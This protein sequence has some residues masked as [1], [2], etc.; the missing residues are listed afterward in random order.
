MI[1]ARLGMAGQTEAEIEG[2]REAIRTSGALAETLEL[3]D[4]LAGRARAALSTAPIQPT[5][6]AALSALAEHVALR[7]S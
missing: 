7:D 4:S 5:A 2:V 6:S 3:I 1:A